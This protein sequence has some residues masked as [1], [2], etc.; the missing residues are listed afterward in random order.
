M[1]A[2]E[3]MT[4]KYEPRESETGG[5]LWVDRFKGRWPVSSKICVCVLI[6]LPPRRLLH[7]SD[8]GQAWLC[9]SFPSVFTFV[10]TLCS[11]FFETVQ[12]CFV[13]QSSR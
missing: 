9:P 2:R 1:K 8:S 10:I 5:A 7:N 4:R 13:Q 12:I 3:S 6:E 11:L